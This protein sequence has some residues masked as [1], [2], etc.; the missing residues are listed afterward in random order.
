M[1]FSKNYPNRKDHRKPYHGSKAFDASCRSHGGCAYCAEGRN[2][3]NKK[4]MGIVEEE[5][6]YYVGVK[7]SV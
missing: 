1:S 3:K 7:H 2:Y 4:R 5:E 6:G